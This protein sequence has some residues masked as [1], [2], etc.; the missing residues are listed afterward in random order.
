MRCNPQP[1]RLHNLPVCL[2]YF[3]INIVLYEIGIRLS[4]GAYFGSFSGE[5][6]EKWGTR[7]STVICS[8]GTYL[9]VGEQRG[10][11]VYLSQVAHE[12]TYKAGLTESTHLV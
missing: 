9:I 10:K 3:I 2:A 6:A 5:K 11:P 1:G 7:V 12:G 4:L 8:S